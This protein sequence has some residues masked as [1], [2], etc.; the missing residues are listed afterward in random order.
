[1]K[2]IAVTAL[3]RL[4][5][6]E[7][8]GCHQSP[9]R[10]HTHLFKI[11]IQLGGQVVFTWRERTPLHPLLMLLAVHCRLGVGD[12][13]ASWIREP[14][15]GGNHCWIRSPRSSRHAG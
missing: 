2:A 7:S 1:M 6:G 8:P 9:T 11:K 12:I 3:R 10:N 5:R 14:L 13:E 4:R 15:A